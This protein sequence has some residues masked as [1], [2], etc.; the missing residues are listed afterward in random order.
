MHLR[1]ILATVLLLTV[2]CAS[3]YRHSDHKV[4][5]QKLNPS[6]GVLI[7]VPADGW[8]GS[9]QYPKT[10]MMT[11]RAV[12]AAFSKHAKRVELVSGCD[13]DECLRAID[14]Q[15]YGYFVWPK[16]LH[17]EERAT[18]WSA[19]PDR[20]EIQITVYDARTKIEIANSSYTGKS[21]LTTFGGDHPQDLLP[22]PTN[23]YVSSLYR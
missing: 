15:Q 10:G 14:V 17:W 3:S 4:Q 13:I 8:Y 7:L 12:E 11:G 6:A 19:K 21:K 23:A 1:I 18:E 5:A 16:I 22:K 9:I 20:I 2:G